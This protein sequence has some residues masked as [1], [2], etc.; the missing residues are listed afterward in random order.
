[1]VLVLSFCVAQ[2]SILGD[3][4]P[5]EAQVNDD[6]AQQVLKLQA[7]KR[8]SMD[9]LEKNAAAI[10]RKWRA[11]HAQE[12]VLNE[13]ELQK[14]SDMKCQGSGSKI[15]PEQSAKEV[16]D[17]V[18]IELPPP[19]SLPESHSVE[20]HTAGAQMMDKTSPSDDAAANQPA[21]KSSVMSDPAVRV[22]SGTGFVDGPIDRLALATSLYATNQFR[23]C[24]KILE[25]VE[26]RP[27]STE[28]RQWHDY[29]FASCY[30]KLGNR[31]DAEDYYRSVLQRSSSTWVSAA[32]RWWLGHIDEKAQLK[33]KLARVQ[34]TVE[35]WRKE[36]DVLKSAN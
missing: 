11:R 24:L 22:A 30:R 33:T 36:I 20:S 14:S 18:F 3:L 9:R 10:A 13:G 21:V 5:E 31:G 12:Q 17:D 1:M 4:L 15:S 19:R 25:A 2:S 32:A 16:M 7:E 29:L 35:N 8:D 6:H 34:T 28:D 23:E 27:L 26:L